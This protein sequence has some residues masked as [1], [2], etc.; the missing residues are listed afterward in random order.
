MMKLFKFF[1]A[2][3]FVAVAMMFSSCEDSVDYNSQIPGEGEAKIEAIFK[4]ETQS[5]TL[6]EPSRTSGTVIGE[7]KDINMFVYDQDGKLYK[8]IF[9]NNPTNSSVF[10]QP[11]PTDYPKDADGKAVNTETG[12]ARVTTSLSLPYGRYYMYAAANLGKELTLENTPAIETID[13]LKNIECKW[14]LTN[15]SD[16]AQMFGY[17]QNGTYSNTTAF[18]EQDPTVLVNN[19]NVTINCW[20]KR[21]A[22]KVTVA[23]DGAG[24][25]SG[26][27]IY[28][29]NVSIRQIPLYCKLGVPNSPHSI[30]SITTDYFDKSMTGNINTEQQILYY[31]SKGVTDTQTFYATNLHNYEDWLHI[32]NGRGILGSKD[33]TNDDPA[34][35]FY[36]NMQG[37]Y[38]DSPNKR[39]YDKRMYKDSVG[40]NVGPWESDDYTSKDYRDNVPFG[41]FIEV[42][43]YYLRSTAPVSYGPIRYR[44]ML[45][46]DCEYNYDAIRNHHYKVTLGFLGEADEP[47]WHIQ[48]KE[49]E[50]EI[51]AA[52]VY[53]PY[54]YNTYV[55][56]P[57]T[58]KGDVTS[59][60]AEIIE[61]NWAP[62]DE[63]GEY[64]VPPLSTYGETNFETRTLQFN[65]W[66]DV[67]VNNSGSADNINI[68]EVSLSGVNRQ[69]TNSA[70]NYLY[71]RHRGYDADGEPLY[72]LKE[73]GSDDTNRPY[74]VSPIW[75]GFLRL[76]QPVEYE[77]MNVNLPAY[78]LRNLSKS[79]AENYG[80]GTG[81][82]VLTAFRNYYFG[83]QA[84]EFSGEAGS[85]NTTD[86]RKRVFTDMTPG[87]HHDD[88]ASGTVNPEVCR[89]AYFVDKKYEGD[90]IYTTI[91]L[92]LWTQPK[93]MC[94]ISAFTG[95]NPYEEYNRKAVVRFTAQFHN[96]VGETRKD[97]SVLQARRIV[98]PKAVWRAHEDPIDHGTPK[99]FNVTLYERTG[100]TRSTFT[101]LES[102]GDWTATITQ[103]NESNFIS[104]VSRGGSSGGGTTVTGGGGSNI[105]FQISFA[106]KIPSNESK[107][108]IIEIKYHGNSAV[109]QIYVRQGYNE[110]IQLVENGPYWSSY[111]VFSCG[112]TTGLNTSWPNSVGAVL[113]TNP[114]AFGAMFKRGAYNGSIS[115]ANISRA[116][117]IFGALAAP[118]DNTF[119]FNGGYTPLKWSNISGNTNQSWE[120]AK[121]EVETKDGTK[122]VY[123]VPTL[124]EYQT[125]VD[126]DFG[127][128]VLYGDGATA[129]GTTTAEA[130]GFMDGDN[131]T[132]SSPYGVRGFIC[133]DPN[134]G[135]AN[136]IFF[137][138]GTM[139]MGRR[140]IQNLNSTAERGIMRYSSV[141]KNLDKYSGD[142]TLRPIAVNMLNSPGAIYWINKATQAEDGGSTWYTGW[143]MNYFDLNF[144]G[145][146][147]NVV[148]IS[149]RNGGGGDALPIRLVYD[150]TLN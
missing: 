76:Q 116:P 142:N 101:P 111:N 124:K 117:D 148:S 114:L 14:N 96:Y 143:D 23:F 109:H 43:G 57:V 81:Q 90:D 31:D 11:L 47:N 103:G 45:G 54:S 61:N 21:L 63:E 67:F 108:A 127:I 36:E 132:V 123:R 24:L 48:Y 75:A 53:V 82:D 130:F 42:E 44:F 20:L 129:P 94:G 86:L 140:T 74:Y 66:R 136:H 105:S 19:N 149:D 119:T 79:G 110:P 77:S 122:R 6:G 32:A 120:F 64:E 37:D 65:W 102:R 131:S 9:L 22:S 34:L 27:N 51:Y 25:N 8:S 49:E 112:S 30:D 138:I 89:N 97:V 18:L 133:Y 139:G 100:T 104:L 85:S 4:F 106:G 134:P 28:I 72:H 59:L 128:G 146:P 26:V 73:D 88:D 92:R 137:P 95:N 113:T 1:L 38:K 115:I 98:N 56:Y 87:W 39:W 118:G 126:G 60:T 71:G 17:F 68:N 3:Q 135:E 141:E 62:Y 70:S 125:L 145:A 80:G 93:T 50:H 99:P 15:I 35:F 150:P 2:F 69:F 55:D 16:N 13:G 52:D 46:Q 58:I 78:L 144:N 83:K 29:H 7:I 12:T 121:F 5:A 40:V 84:A 41:T 147:D 107:C 33:H 10:P 91:T